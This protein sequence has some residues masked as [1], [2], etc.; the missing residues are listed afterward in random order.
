[1]EGREMEG[2]RMERGV[3]D[4]GRDRVRLKM[5]MHSLII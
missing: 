1:M 2:K 4:K 5:L 3:R